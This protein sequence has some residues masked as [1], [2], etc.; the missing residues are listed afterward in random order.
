MSKH[1]LSNMSKRPAMTLIEL[2]LALI[3]LMVILLA[4]TSFHL[5]S[6]EFVRSSQRRAE[7]IND[8]AFVLDHL[9]KNIT[10]ATGAVYDPGIS[11]DGTNLRVRQDLNSVQTPGDFSDDTWQTYVFD[12]NDNT[13]TFSGE[14][15]TD[16]FVNLDA[17]V[18]NPTGIQMRNLAFRFN[19]VKSVDTRRNP[20]VTTTAMQ[21][22]A[23]QQSAR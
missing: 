19:P 17:L 9:Q 4:A 21:F 2:L 22:A 8:L 12:L 1:I 7:I 15:L 3:F 18:V 23:I 5:S 10:Q 16:R 20:Q 11:W 14:E 6:E 13:I